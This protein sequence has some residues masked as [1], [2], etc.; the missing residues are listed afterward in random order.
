MKS[1]SLKRTA[2][3][4]AF[5]AGLAFAPISINSSLALGQEAQV[6]SATPK[7]ELVNELF[8]RQWVTANEM[9]DVTGSV[10]GLVPNDKTT[11]A[12][13]AVYLV[14]DS[15]VELKTKADAE[16]KFTLVGVQPGTYSLIVRGEEAF[17]AFSLKV[18]SR[19]K[20]LHLTSDVEVRV[21]KPADKVTEI[22]RGQ[23]LPPYAMR[24]ESS[25]ETDS[26]P[27]GPSR[28]FSPSQVVSADAE[29][30]LVGTVGSVKGDKDLSDLT[31]F[32]LKDG[33]EVA[34]ALVAPNG[35][36]V[37]SG[38]EPGVYGFVAAGESGFVATS[39]EFVPNKL[40]PVNA[41]GEKL[42]GI[43]RPCHRLNAEVVPCCDTASID[44]VSTEIVEVVEAPAEV[45]C[46]ETQPAASCCG[47]MGWGGYG[48]GGGGGG[49]HGGG[50][51][52][53]AGIAGLAAVAGILAA[54]DDDEA[55][56]VSPAA[57]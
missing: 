56:V 53:I 26:D 28:S 51:G 30:R 1:S 22:L 40:D 55:P 15:K 34:K 43:F 5:G 25:I 54:E 35:E 11:A 23:T 36:Y 46:E 41:K 2:F 47:G 16:G 9:G 38:L 12:D 32:I 20:G 39:F 37:V 18:L 14:K 3:L 48:G 50:W 7:A 21:V 17:G 27:L 10:V 52:G 49:A 57:P 24:I 44:V 8:S 19:E 29:G 33:E 45:L 42:I 6:V 13:L 4:A 31:V